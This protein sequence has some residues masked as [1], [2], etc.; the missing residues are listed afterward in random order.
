MRMRLLAA[1]TA[2]ALAALGVLTAPGT[3]VAS[4]S[5]GGYHWARTA[6]P[7]TVELDNN[8]TSAWTSSNAPQRPR[9]RRAGDHLQPP[10]QHQHHPGVQ[11]P[12]LAVGESP[13]TWGTL[14]RGSV[15]RHGAAT[16]HRDLGSG[17]QVITFV[18]WA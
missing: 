18:L 10:R 9:L 3:A 8:L 4:H 12:S 5:W 14:T 17:Q 15:D 13:S 2:A 16:Y 6:N 1:A 7:F 11:G